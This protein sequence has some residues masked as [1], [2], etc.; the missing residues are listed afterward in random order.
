MPQKR[1]T[2]AP[3]YWDGVLDPQNLERS[4]KKSPSC[5]TLEDE[6][7]FARTPDFDAALGWL[8]SDR[9]FNPQSPIPNPQSYDLVDLGAGL[10]A[11]SFAF[12]RAGWRV[13]A[14]DTSL[15]RLSALRRRA[16][17]AACAEQIE[18]VVA[19]A[20]A[21]PFRDESLG[22][23]YTKSVLIHTDLERA[24]AELART[25]ADGGRAALV[26]PQPGNPFARMYRR[27]LGPREWRSITRY[28]DPQ[29][30]AL[31]IDAHAG[32]RKP[33]SRVQPF[34]LFGFLAF[35]F[36]FGRPR[37]GLFRAALR[38]TMPL[39]RL[40]F[41]LFPRLRRW[42][43]FGVIE[44]EIGAGAHGVAPTGGVK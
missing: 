11:N 33:S 21:L 4:G 25:L 37:V 24:A 43:W 3:A 7:A 29:A 16:A 8:R 18:C 19:A 42:A 6:I 23:V 27:W 20:E 12:A 41:R 5:L 13:V 39:D 10:G 17:E 34:Y 15:K 44:L 28:F 26:E 35:F 40:L 38:L 36:Q 31:F 30:Q 14:V 2:N 32:M 1:N 9:F 22:A